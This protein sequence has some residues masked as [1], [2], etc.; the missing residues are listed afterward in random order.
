YVHRLSFI[1]TVMPEA[2]RRGMGVIG[3]KA[4]S[5]GRLLGRGALSMSEAMGYVLSLPGV[6]TVI[7][8]CSTPEEV[9]ENAR[10]ARAF[11]PFAAEKMRALEARTRQRAALFGY[12]KKPT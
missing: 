2:A 3:M 11:T 1:Q 6:S 5:Q 4:T 9:D 12:F 7:V 10:I 8:G